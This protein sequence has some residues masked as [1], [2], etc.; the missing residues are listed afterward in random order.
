[1]SLPILAMDVVDLGEQRYLV[2]GT[3][4]E[5][6]TSPSRRMLHLWNADKAEVERS[7]LPLRA[8]APIAAIVGS[9][10]MGA[11]MVVRDDTFWAVLPMSDS[12]YKLDAD[13]SQI[14]ALP[15][16]LAGQSHLEAS[17]TDEHWRIFGLHVTRSGKIVVQVAREVARREFVFNLVIMDRNGNIEAMLADTPQLRVV[18]D[19]V[20]YFQDPDRLEPNR[21]IAVYLA[22]R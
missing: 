7:F 19:D 13:G 10:T 11:E 1:M 2:S 8:P 21:W 4:P 14:D 22:N 12:V 15:L 16:P 17:P 6:A 5:N 3:V 18:A 20:F 9:M